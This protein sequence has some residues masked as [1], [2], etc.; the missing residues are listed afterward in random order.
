[1]ASENN[2]LPVNP[3]HDLPDDLKKKNRTRHRKFRNKVFVVFLL[4]SLLPIII[5]SSSNLYVI[6]K[7]R[8]QNISEM[9][10][11]A[12]NNAYEKITKYLNQKMEGL[13][14]VVSGKQSSVSEQVPAKLTET[15]PNNLIF[16]LQKRWRQENTNNVVESINFIDTDGTIILK[17]D[18][19]GKIYLKKYFPESIAII[20]KDV[21]L[22][23]NI[24]DPAISESGAAT[25][26]NSNLSIGYR[27]NDPIVRINASIHNQKDISI[28]RI[29]TEVNLKTLAGVFQDGLV[30]ERPV[31]SLLAVDPDSLILLLREASGRYEEKLTNLSATLNNLDFTD[32][33]G[34]KIGR[35]EKDQVTIKLYSTEEIKT[36]DSSIQFDNGQ[37]LQ[38]PSLDGNGYQN[39]IKN[40]N[41]LEVYRCENCS[42]DKKAKILAKV[43]APIN[44]KK[45][46]VIG[47][48]EAVI[49][50][51][52]L[53]NNLENIRLGDATKKLT[54][55]DPNNLIYLLKSVKQ[56]SG[57]DGSIKKIK[58]IDNDGEVLAAINADDQITL[59]KD[60][61]INAIP[62]AAIAEAYRTGLVEADFI[63]ENA[64]N[65]ND[66]KTA[67]YGQR[68]FGQLE[69]QEGRPTMKLAS[70]FENS[71]R[72]RIGV[73]S[74]ELDL[75]PIEN[76]IKDIA[77]GTTGYLYVTDK[78][79]NVIASP[80]AEFAKTG[81]NLIDIALV[82]DVLD[83]HIH[84]GLKKFENYTNHNNIEVIFAGTPMTSVTPGGVDW[85][86]L[87]EWPKDD[88]YSVIKDIVMVSLGIA[89]ATIIIIIFLG[90]IFAGQ[91]VK[92]IKSLVHGAQEIAKGNLDYK[93]KIRT[94]DEFDILSAR[95]NDMVQILKENRK[96]R[97]E[98]VFISAHELRTPVTAIKGY[99]SMILDKT[100]GEVPQAVKENLEIV[101]ASNERLVQ[102]VNDLLEVARSEAGKMKINMEA[103]PI[104]ENVTTVLN[105]L[106]S[107]SDKKG[108]KVSYNEPELSK[109]P[110]MADPYKLKEVLTNLIG[111]AIKYTLG[112][113]DIQIT[114]EKKENNLIIHIKDHGMGMT[115]EDVSKLFAKFYRVQNDNTAAIEGTGLGLF[116]CKEIVERMKGKIWVESEVGKGSTFSFSLALS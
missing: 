87:S 17:M 26:Q 100:F 16:L 72:E 95:F 42:T 21:A 105:E 61:W 18:K 99:L 97:D 92:P 91:I 6:I 23:E 46:E 43:Y 115:P 88:A 73:V 108:I 45:Q 29:L 55:I 78:N 30:I 7:T 94:H 114:H 13:N 12:I 63:D 85:Y 116:I 93:I 37:I 34:E 56:T 81:E 2:N 66:F 47:A 110:V 65:D 101:N 4:I 68:Y 57:A 59:K 79:G 103:T 24:Y 89:L 40:L 33:T 41:F 104:G 102:L 48:L 53:N 9:Q 39:I 49:D 58:F 69:I 77:V 11:L 64:V 15:N 22:I 90:I 51:S 20:H 38:N 71:D 50:S 10:N 80:N 54:E 52:F 25:N 27:G 8:Q 14:L 28:G 111:N 19:A 67:I 1:M 113:G 112:N 84:D 109:L 36:L 76:T 75:S 98:F 96:L 44:N 32:K 86:I 106:K 5:I 3:D 107:L 74:A 31:P 35:I 82:K 62:S 60:Y 83:G 70:Q